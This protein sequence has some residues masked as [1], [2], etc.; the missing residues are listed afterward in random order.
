MKK[1]ARAK[2]SFTPTVPR[3]TGMSVMPQALIMT[4]GQEALDLIRK[5]EEEGDPVECPLCGKELEVGD[6][7]FC[8]GNPE[9]HSKD[10]TYHFGGNFR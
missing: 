7:P 6:W 1:P 5:W 3:P 8:D 2:K 9:D 10:I 4:K